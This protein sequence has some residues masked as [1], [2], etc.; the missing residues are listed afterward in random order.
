[1]LFRSDLGLVAALR[2]HCETFSRRFG[3]DVECESVGPDGAE[4]LPA[5]AEVAVYR[6][7]QE[8]LSNAVRHGAARSVHVLLQRKKEAMLVI[9]EDDGHG[10]DASDWRARCARGGHLGLLGIE[11]RAALLGGTLRV[12]SRPGSGT[13]LFVEIPL[14]AEVSHVEDPGAHRG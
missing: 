1:M 5:E 11:E 9:V 14:P 10:F 8:A 12:E 4:S 2:R 3:V 7:A 13:S 6:I